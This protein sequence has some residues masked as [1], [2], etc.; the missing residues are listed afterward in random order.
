MFA[1]AG[2]LSAASMARRSGASMVGSRLRRLLPPVWVYG[3]IAVLGGWELVGVHGL[4]WARLPYW[5]LPLRDPHESPAGSG[6]VDTLWYLRTYVW[7]VLLTPLALRAYRRAPVFTTVAPL[8]ALPFVVFAPV[9]AWPGRGE[10]IAALTYG[11]CW[12]LGFADQDG[13][14]RRV[15]WRICGC[16]A[17]AG[18]ILGLALLLNVNQ[19]NVGPYNMGYALWSAAVVVVLLRWRPDVAGLNRSRALRRV[20]SVVN[21][22]AVTIYLWHDAAIVATV[23]LLHRA[24]ADPP[25]AVRL[26]LVLVLTTVLM[27]ALGWVEDLAAGRRP[28][29]LPPAESTSEGEV[30]G[31]G[32]I[33]MTENRHETV[34]SRRSP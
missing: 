9:G 10:V 11:T 21:A 2:S 3:L 15:S 29:I 31:G 32:E 22:R 34:G 16:L 26:L 20:V 8:A 33:G 13:S 24:G 17:A 23:V 25:A 18:A 7:F 30:T 14:L 19:V 28:G 6:F 1:L 5:I 4:D 27:G 12:V